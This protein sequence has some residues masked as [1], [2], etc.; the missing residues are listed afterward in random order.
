MF[1]KS[2]FENA[3]AFAKMEIQKI[4]QIDSGKRKK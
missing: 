4:V 2:M 1:E 3:A